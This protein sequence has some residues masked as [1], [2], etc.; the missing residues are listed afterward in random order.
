MTFNAPLIEAVV[1]GAV[2][3]TV[4][5]SLLGMV[6]WT[7]RVYEAQALTAQ[8]I[9]ATRWEPVIRDDL[10]HTVSWQGDGATWLALTMPD[11]SRVAYSVEGAIL[12][13]N[14]A[15]MLR[16][17][18]SISM[19]AGSRNELVF[20]VRFSHGAHVHRIVVYPRYLSSPS[21]SP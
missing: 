18:Q 20:D 15:V 8:V 19:T 21:S 3:I 5:A 17:V 6:T 10:L 9:L 14:G 11:G 7:V 13:R 16:G 1:W 4:A 2:A 12:R